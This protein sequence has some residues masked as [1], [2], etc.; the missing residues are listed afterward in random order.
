MFDLIADLISG[1]I[2]YT[3]WRHLPGDGYS[4]DKKVKRI[5]IGFIISALV[6]SILLIVYS[7]I[8]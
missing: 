8:R 3:V 5:G 2:E 6:A 1:A 4:R 7:N